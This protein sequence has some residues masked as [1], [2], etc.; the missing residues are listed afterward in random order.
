[1]VVAR[2]HVLAAQDQTAP[3]AAST[4]TETTA[5][6]VSVVAAMAAR[7]APVQT[8]DLSETLALVHSASSVR[9]R[10]VTGASPT[11]VRLA[12]ALTVDPQVREAVEDLSV[13]SVL[14]RGAWRVAVLESTV[15]RPRMVVKGPAAVVM[16]PALS[17]PVF[18]VA[19]ADLAVMMDAAPG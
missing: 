18:Q 12:L 5:T 14:A 10:D 7:L 13:P 8:A 4:V 2:A 17:H 19:A 1:M 3:E 11:T 15:H 6:S 9:D 16:A